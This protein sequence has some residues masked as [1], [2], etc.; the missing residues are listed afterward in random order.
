MSAAGGV[1]IG[2]WAL[3]WVVVAVAVLVA[4][5]MSFFLRRHGEQDRAQAHWQR[6]DEVFVDPSTNRLMRVWVEPGTGVR[7]YVA[8]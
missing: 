4:I 8:D 3:I 2:L 1:G 6:T 5:V 7:H